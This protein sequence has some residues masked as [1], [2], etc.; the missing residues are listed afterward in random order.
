MNHSRWDKELSDELFSIYYQ[1]VSSVGESVSKS[2]EN[3]EFDA[4]RTASFLRLRA[5]KVATDINNST[6]RRLA[7]VKS[8]DSDPEVIDNIFGETRGE[9]SG[10]TIGTW[11]VG[12]TLY[13]TTRQ[14][15]WEEEMKLEKTWATTSDNPRE[16]H[17]ALDGS[18]VAWD[19][20]FSNG[21]L[22]PGDAAGSPEET[23]KCSCIITV[24]VAR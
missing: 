13:E 6:E 18:T 17:A 2:L 15:S 5:E 10:N 20:Q 3:F 8:G 9:N 19:E 24:Q 11:G 23:A 7:E 16:T 4:E 21:L 1:I 14:L 12:W 22:H